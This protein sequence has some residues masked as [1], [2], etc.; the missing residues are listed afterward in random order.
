[1]KLLGVWFETY[2]IAGGAV[3]ADAAEHSLC[4]SVKYRHL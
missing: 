3:V 2:F 1:M 4:M